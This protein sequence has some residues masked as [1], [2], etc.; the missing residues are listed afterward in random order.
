MDPR[1]GNDN[2]PGGC[3]RLINSPQGQI[4][5]EDMDLCRLSQ[6]KQPQHSRPGRGLGLSE[7][8]GMDYLNN[9]IWNG[10]INN[11]FPSHTAQQGDRP[12]V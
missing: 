2:G 12:A 10:N 9:D 7:T 3:V 8:S 6:P 4:S 5:S 1:P 11:S